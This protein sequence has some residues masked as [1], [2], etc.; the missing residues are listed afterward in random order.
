MRRR[1]VGVAVALVLATLGTTVLMSYVAGARERAVKGGKLVEVLVIK[2]DIPA[3]TPASALAAKVQVTR[4]P[5]TAKAAGTV[6]DLSQLGARVTSAALFKGEQLVDRRFVT[7]DQVAAAG[8]PPNSLRVTVALD[9]QRALGGQVRP[10]D[11][12]GIVASFPGESAS[13]ATTHLILHKVVV[14]GVQWEEP[15]AAGSAT[16][17]PK[18]GQAAPAQAPTA[19]LLITFAL[20]APSIES[21]V[22]AAEH[23]T[24]WL[25]AEPADANEAGT[26]L[27]NQ[28]TVLR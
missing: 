16:T 19:K 26:S 5:S 2:E 8:A 25:A 9:P 22:F 24:V 13:T 7:A 20:D 12:V 10:G 28:A 11:R 14:A 4:V 18:N 27:H 17:V 21:V 1:F 6:A 23:G 3:G 15:A